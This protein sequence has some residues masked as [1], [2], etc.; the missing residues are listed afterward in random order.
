MPD[1]RNTFIVKLNPGALVGN[2]RYE[3]VDIIGEGAMGTVYLCRRKDLDDRVFT[4]KA[5]RPDIASDLTIAERFRNE[6]MA[7]F[8]VSHK[9]I[10]RA[11]DY[12]NEDGLVA[13]TMEYVE[14][15]DL[16]NYLLSQTDRIP[17]KNA[18]DIMMEIAEGTEA[19]HQAGIIHRDLKPENVLLSKEGHV[20]ISDFGIS[21]IGNKKRQT[22]TGSLVGT[23]N[24][25]SP[26]Y[27]LEGKVDK[28]SD[29]YAIGVIAYELLTKKHPFPGD[30]MFQSMKKQ[31]DATFDPPRKLRPDCPMIL[32]SI[33][34]KCLRI[35][36][37]DRYQSCAEIFQEL[38]KAKDYK[39]ASTLTTG[40]TL[41]KLP[42]VKLEIEGVE[43]EES[44]SQSVN[45]N[46]PTQRNHPTVTPSSGKIPTKT[47][48]KS[49]LQTNV[50]KET[51]D[52]L[53][54]AVTILIIVAALIMGTIA[55][56]S[57]IA[58]LFKAH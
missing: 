31:V 21:I 52:Y 19:L 55:F 28:R 6:V 38:K 35:N 12:I 50:A 16:A 56:S 26:E 51:A 27:L 46:K 47:N 20:K 14:G 54:L 34:L 42:A 25:L 22:Q 5:L 11:Y 29:I 7:A 58:T 3:I 37:D 2:K 39:P 23:V 15:G 57:L 13:Y 49:P 9:N 33:I 8:D 48:F 53:N 30:S 32:E 36:P 10:V 24:Y 40:T 17:V 43:Q 4:L 44:R 18:I 41:P 1:E 45:N